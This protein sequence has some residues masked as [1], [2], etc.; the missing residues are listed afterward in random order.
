[1][2]PTLHR[3]HNKF[4]PSLHSIQPFDTMNRAQYGDGPTA[5][6]YQPPYTYDGNF[7]GGLP[8]LMP[9]P[10]G[11]SIGVPALDHQHHHLPPPF[12]IG[13]LPYPMINFPPF[14]GAQPRFRAP[15]A[16]H[17][18]YRRK[19]RGVRGRG[20]GWKGHKRYTVSKGFP[21]YWYHECL[22]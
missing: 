13:G 7:P 20:G 4:M 14:Y 9:M 19:K 17:H 8:Y 2:H 6:G 11:T 3:N 5:I 16:R 18:Y 1:M 12:P 22:K 10:P 21:C 15:Q